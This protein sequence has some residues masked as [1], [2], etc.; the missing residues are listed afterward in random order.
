MEKRETTRLPAHLV[1]A[2]RRDEVCLGVE[3]E[4][5]GP[6]VLP[7]AGQ[8][9]FVAGR[10]GSGRTSTLLG[11]AQ[12][13][14]TSLLPPRRVVLVGPRATAAPGA[15]ADLVLTR[16]GA[17]TVAEL[18]L[19]GRPAILV[20]YPQAADDHQRANAARLEAAGAA[21]LVPQAEI[22]TRPRLS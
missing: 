8:G 4:F 10:G 18:L 3:A 14:A 6:V 19:L 11:L 15:A 13:A 5:A 16:S 1:P 17:S 2:G 9:L 21:R 22:E 7:L 20:P 12:A